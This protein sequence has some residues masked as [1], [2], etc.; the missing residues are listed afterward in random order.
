MLKENYSLAY[1]KAPM[2]KPAASGDFFTCTV[3][4]KETIY[5]IAKRYNVKIDEIVKW[6]QLDGYELKMGQQLKINK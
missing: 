5:S 3:Q 4:P 6:N 1:I 2:M